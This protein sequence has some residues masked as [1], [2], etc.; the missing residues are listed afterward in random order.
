MRRKTNEK[1]F[2]HLATKII[3]F[4]AEQ[5]SENIVRVEVEYRRKIEIKL[6]FFK[7]FYFKKFKLNLNK[8]FETI[9]IK[10]T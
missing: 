3:F 6:K 4:N 8:K 7:F 5:K 9:K 10:S 1:S 2:F